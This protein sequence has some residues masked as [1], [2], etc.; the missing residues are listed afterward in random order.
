[1]SDENPEWVNKIL[2]LV[3]TKEAPDNLAEDAPEWLTTVYPQLDDLLKCIWKLGY[4]AAIGDATNI[5]DEE[6]VNI[7]MDC[8][9]EWAESK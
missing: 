1:M 3:R 4:L 9:K 2:N 7:T 5:I 8:L 6:E